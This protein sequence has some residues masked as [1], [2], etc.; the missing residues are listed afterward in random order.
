MYLDELKLGQSAVIEEL[1][2]QLAAIKLLEMGCLPGEEVLMKLKAPFND[3][4]AIE[5][6]GNLISLRKAEARRI[7]VKLIAK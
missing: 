4:I 1:C 7:R 3:P 2:D 5:I 6:D